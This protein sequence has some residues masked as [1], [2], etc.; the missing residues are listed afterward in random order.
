MWLRGHWIMW[1]YGGVFLI[2]SH[3]PAKFGGLRRCASKD[4]LILVC[5]VASRD[6]VVRES[7]EIM[8][9]FILS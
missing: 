9:V 7:R 4:I 3:H 6:Y 5:Q 1:H 2:V 8:G